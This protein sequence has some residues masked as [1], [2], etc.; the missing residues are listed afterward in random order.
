MKKLIKKRERKKSEASYASIDWEK[1]SVLFKNSELTNRKKSFPPV[2]ELL[3]VIAAAGAVGLVFAFPGAAPAVGA[4]FMGEKGYK[5]WQS[6]KILNQLCKQKYVAIDYNQDNSITV[7][8][9]KRGLERALTYKLDAL[10]IRKPNKWDYQWRVVIFDIP[11]KHRKLRDLFRIRLTQL[12]LYQFQES[13]YVSPYPCFDE[14]EFLRELYGVSF[15]V[16]YILAQ[17]IEEDENLKDHFD[18]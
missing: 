6:K 7:K 1:A 8:I 4:L 9:T 11:E 13:V 2:R 10:T 16:K 14:I 3:P 12:G 15:T 5:T 18:L 17:K